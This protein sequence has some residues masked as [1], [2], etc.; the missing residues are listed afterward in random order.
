[1][2]L[3]WRKPIGGLC[4][5]CDPQVVQA[6]P[7]VYQPPPGYAL[8]PLSEVGTGC[9]LD[10]ILKNPFTL[11]EVEQRYWVQ[12]LHGTNTTQQKTPEHMYSTALLCIT[13]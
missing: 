11:G 2:D 10:T 6:Q 5:L 1:M 9:T 3:L 8:V 4:Q 13:C 7:Q 12:G